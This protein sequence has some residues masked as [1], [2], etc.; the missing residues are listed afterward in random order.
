MPDAHKN[1]TGAIAALRSEKNLRRSW[2]LEIADILESF[3]STAANQSGSERAEVDALRE[4]IPLADHDKIGKLVLSQSWEVQSAIVTIAAHCTALTDE[5]PTGQVA[6]LAGCISLCCLE[7]AHALATPPA[8]PAPETTH[9]KPD[10]AVREALNIFLKC[11]YPVSK[12]IN[13]RGYNWSEAYLDRAKPIAEAALH[14]PKIAAA[15]TSPGDVLAMKEACKRI[16][17]D[18]ATR[19]ANDL[20]TPPNI[21]GLGPDNY[22]LSY[23]NHV[24]LEIAAAIDRLAVKP[25]A[26]SQEPDAVAAWADSLGLERPIDAEAM[27][28]LRNNPTTEI[29]WSRFSIPLYTHPIPKPEAPAVSVDAIHE[30]VRHQLEVYRMWGNSNE[31]AKAITSAIAAL[32]AGER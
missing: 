29:Y 13:P 16:A 5:H 32:I 9:G 7:L 27:K 26:K 12:V 20:V 2:R 30:A 31:A 28:H 21:R 8:Q 18:L 19:C 11:A 17:T 22:S 14:S 23:G 24:A 10:G 3:A 25:E 6:D 4:A 15:E 1:I